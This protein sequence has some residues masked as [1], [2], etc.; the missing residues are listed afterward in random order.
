MP[1]LILHLLFP[2]YKKGCEALQC[3]FMNVTANLLGLGNAAT[4]FG[5]AA[6][7]AM[8]REIGP[9]RIATKEMRLFVLINTASLQLITT[10]LL[11]MRSEYHS[12]DPFEIVP[13]VWITSFIVLIA[14]VLAGKLCEKAVGG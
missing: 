8:E 12:V 10:T 5:L 4:P 11:A 2:R 13:A 6:M 9:N 7:T 1:L 3:I 14:V